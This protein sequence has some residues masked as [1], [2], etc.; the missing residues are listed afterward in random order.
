M[1]WTEKMVS[2]N[3]LANI[4]TQRGKAYVYDAVK[5]QLVDG[6]LQLGW[7]IDKELKTK[8]RIKQAKPAAASPTAAVD[9]V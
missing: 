4:R 9:A 8:V 1:D 2:G 5:P 7:E 6:Y 3:D